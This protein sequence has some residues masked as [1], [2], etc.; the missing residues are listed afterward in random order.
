MVAHILKS[1]ARRRSNREGHDLWTL[2]AV[3]ERQRCL[4][5]TGIRPRCLER[6]VERG[7]DYELPP[8]PLDRVRDPFSLSNGRLEVGV[9]LLL[10]AGLFAGGIG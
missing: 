1:R 4:E 10:L 2:S 7:V 3:A 9:T 8:L 6:M 5:W